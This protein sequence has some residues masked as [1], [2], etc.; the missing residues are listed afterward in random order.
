M[1]V[2]ALFMSILLSANVQAAR[3]SSQRYCSEALQA[4]L[5]ESVETGA[6]AF[7]IW[8][9]EQ[10]AERNIGSFQEVAQMIGISSGSQA[11]HM[12]QNVPSD[13]VLLEYANAFHLSVATIKQQ[14]NRI[15]AELK[16]QD[17]QPPAASPWLK[18]WVQRQMAANGIATF[19]ELAV[20]MGVT[21]VGQHFRREAS[22]F[23]LEK[24]S[25]FFGVPL[26]EILREKEKILATLPALP[27]DESNA[28]P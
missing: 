1:R 15:K 2:V 10:M 4:K 7:Q 22:E 17:P 21:D 25:R 23:V 9:L 24:Y 5:A 8:L 26:D 3:L 14:L 16:L 27:L 19:K 12:K 6:P 20:R 11:V 28:K 13:F 18:I